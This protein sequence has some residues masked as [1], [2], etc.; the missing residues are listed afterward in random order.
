M[1]LT[2]GLTLY[3]PDLVTVAFGPIIVD[4]YADGEFV[5]IEPA[6]EIFT[7]YAGTDGKITRSKQ[8]RRDATIT[9]TL[10]SSSATNDALTAV[11]ELD[12]RAPN[13]AGILPLFIRDNGGRALYTAAQAWIEALPS[14]TFDR[15]ATPRAWVLACADL[16]RVDGGN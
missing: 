3:D 4:G 12:R 5:A 13:G 9:F 15:Q 16:I 14:V 8:L 10:A 2:P 11:A 6:S 7:R 1:S